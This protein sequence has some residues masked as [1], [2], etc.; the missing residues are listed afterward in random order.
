MKTSLSKRC[1]TALGLCVAVWSLAAGA[2]TGFIVKNTQSASG[3]S[4]GWPAN[5]TFTQHF[6]A[7]E[8]GT[9]TELAIN[10][11]NNQNPY[12]MHMAMDVAGRR[13]Y[14]HHFAG[15]KQRSS[16][17]ATSF[18]IS[19]MTWTIRK[20]DVVTISLTPNTMVGMEPVLVDNP[21]WPR[22]ELKGYGRVALRFSVKTA[23]AR[24][25]I[26]P[27]ALGAVAWAEGMSC[28]AACAFDANLGTIVT[29]H[30]KP[31]A[32]NRLV[33]WGPPCKGSDVT[34]EIM[35]FAGMAPMAPVTATFARIPV[36]AAWDRDGVPLTDGM[37]VMVKDNYTGKFLSTNT[38][39]TNGVGLSNTAITLDKLTDAEK[40]KVSA[41]ER[42]DWAILNKATYQ[43][44]MLRLTNLANDKVIYSGDS[45]SVG[46][47][48]MA[49]K[50]WT[51]MTG[52]EQGNQSRYFFRVRRYDGGT[53]S[54]VT[55]RGDNSQAWLDGAWS[56]TGN[57]YNHFCQN[58]TPQ[59]TGAAAATMNCIYYDPSRQSYP[60]AIST[61][62][63]QK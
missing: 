53:Q 3:K 28:G 42:I 25:T 21:A 17:W 48:T 24:V 57:P 46:G 54:A 45:R 32:G 4:Y 20:G 60:E 9:P 59:A 12:N 11:G 2:D 55:V 7:A 35:I 39:A 30:A 1:R 13:V 62:Y 10:M 52:S 41:S 29:L 27:P 61:I 31:A 15:L 18:P 37:V 40:W 56:Y 63:Y 14:D 51:Q 33:S 49:G 16:D 22:A 44:Y 38:A 26:T 47:G 43:G 58:S 5:F 50:P 8:G 6:I 23:Q 34:C 19:G 36:I